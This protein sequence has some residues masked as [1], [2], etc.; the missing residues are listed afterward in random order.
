MV[1]NRRLF[2]VGS[3]IFVRKQFGK[4]VVEAPVSPEKVF[5]QMIFDKTKAPAKSI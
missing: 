3:I 5:D 4:K 2:T 1:C